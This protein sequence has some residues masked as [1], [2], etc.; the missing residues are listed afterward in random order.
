VLLIV[1]AYFGQIN[2]DEICTKRTEKHFKLHFTETAAK[3]LKNPK[4][5]RAVLAV[6]QG[7]IHT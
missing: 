1:T 5:S 3:F 2:D 7:H 4:N 6:C